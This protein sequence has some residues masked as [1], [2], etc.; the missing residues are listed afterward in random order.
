IAPAIVTLTVGDGA[1]P[2]IR[3]GIALAALTIVVVAVAISRSREI[4]IG[5]DVDDDDAPVVAPEAAKV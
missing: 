5:G 3:W 1:N 2:M 4:G